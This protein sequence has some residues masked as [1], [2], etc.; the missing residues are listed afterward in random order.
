[1]SKLKDASLS[2]GAW[3]GVFV[4]VDLV[5][6]R[7][8]AALEVD[9]S[10]IRG[11]IS[12]GVES[13]KNPLRVRGTLAGTIEGQNIQFTITL[14]LTAQEQSG[15]NVPVMRFAGSYSDLP[16]GRQ[17]ILAI[18][19][20]DADENKQFRSNDVPFAGTLILRSTPATTAMLTAAQ[21]SDPG[22]VD[23]PTQ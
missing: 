12:F 19:N 16:I 1:M 5:S 15:V 18:T 13:K 6:R 22:W 8:A 9:G 10:S 7:V 3:Q 17:V 21:E 11:E 23:E 14:P 4:G 20:S 2:G